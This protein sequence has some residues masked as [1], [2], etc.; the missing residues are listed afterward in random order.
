MAEIHNKIQTKT[1]AG[2][3]LILRDIRGCDM[4][5]MVWLVKTGFKMHMQNMSSHIKLYK[6]V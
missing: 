1:K 6:V 5:F 2:N 3:Q 4:C